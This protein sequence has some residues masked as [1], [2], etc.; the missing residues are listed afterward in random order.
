MS[1]KMSSWLP[2]EYW[3]MS[4][5][6]MRATGPPN[7]QSFGPRTPIRASLGLCPDNT[8]KFQ[9]LVRSNVISK[10]SPLF[11]GNAVLFWGMDPPT[12][13]YFNAATRL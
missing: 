2:G 7:S 5:C 1:V 12:Y 8:A 11:R 13:M 4:S 10:K 9:S 6:L 3:M